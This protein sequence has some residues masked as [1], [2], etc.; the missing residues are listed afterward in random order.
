MNKL[1]IINTPRKIQ[2]QHAKTERIQYIPFPIWKSDII[3]P[4]KD[5]ISHQTDYKHSNDIE[6]ANWDLL[7]VICYLFSTTWAELG[8]LKL[9]ER[10]G[11]VVGCIQHGGVLGKHALL[12]DKRVC[13]PL[14]ISLTILETHRQNG[15][16]KIIITWSALTPLTTK[17][18]TTWVTTKWSISMTTC[19]W[20]WPLTFRISLPLYEHELRHSGHNS[21]YR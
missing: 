20:H 2:M 3:Q 15:V 1:A 11:H 8:I 7:K 5:L 17:T 6:L 9:L 21:P 14:F 10:L 18:L 19:H 13:V 16:W 4:Q 12:G